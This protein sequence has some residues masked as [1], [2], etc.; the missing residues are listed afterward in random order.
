MAKRRAHHEG[1]IHRRKDGRWSGAIDVGVVNGK[2]TRKQV[3][4]ATQGEVREKLSKVRGDLEVGIAPSDDRVTVGAFLTR[5]LADVVESASSSLKPSTQISYANLARNHLIP[6]LGHHKLSK[7][8]PLDVQ[9]FLT[10]KLAQKTDDGKSRLSART[11]QYLHAVL[12]KALEQALRWGLVARN[13]AKLVDAPRVSRDEVRPLV[14]ADALKVIDVVDTHR[15]RAMITVAFSLGLRRGEISGLRWDDVDLDA[16]VLRVRNQVQRV[17]GKGL[18]MDEPKSKRSRR[19]LSLPSTVVDELRAHRRKQA[20]ERLA[21]G[22]AWN[23]GGFVFATHSG[24]PLDGRWIHRFWTD[25]LVDAG[26][27]HHRFHD[28][29]HTAATLLLAQGVEMKT[30]QD[31]LGHSGFA[32]TAN[33]YA[34]TTSGQMLNA[35]SKMDALLRR[36]K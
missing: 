28:A 8:S 27:A 5:W 24:G 20:V 33:T 15:L 9:A 19:V 10:A 35:A 7:F 22:A 3:Y 30:V 6:A 1:T 18:V 31:V 36:E 2:R 34:H 4:G 11:V 23:D 25:K 14:L 17:R 29:R 26:V 16:A 12:R 32:L 21:A 13:V